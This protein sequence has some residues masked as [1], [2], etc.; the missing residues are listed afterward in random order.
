METGLISSEMRFLRRT[1]GYTRWDHKRNGRYFNRI[2]NVTDN[3]IHM[4]VQ[5]K[6]ERAC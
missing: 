5:E 3:R 2:T 6:L 1:A 4:S